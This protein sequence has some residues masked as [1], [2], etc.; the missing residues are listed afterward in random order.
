VV[1]TCALA[2]AT[3]S[4]A[5]SKAPT[6]VEPPIF[7]ATSL[8][9]APLGFAITP[10]QALALAKTAPKLDAIHRLTMR[11]TGSSTSGVSTTTRSISRST[12]SWVADQI[13]SA[14]QWSGRPTYIGGLMLGVC[15][16]AHYGQVFDSP[17]VLVPFTLMVPLPLLLLR[18][19][20]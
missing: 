5:T 14:C 20:N 17:W 18:R 8:D 12:A 15:A 9:K 4:A 1:V 6:D 7:K 10:R 3:A 16:H 13:V 2:L 19:C 11:S